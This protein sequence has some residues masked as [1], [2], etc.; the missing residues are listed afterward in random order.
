MD[1]PEMTSLA[2]G[3]PHPSLFP[4]LRAD[5]E[6][7]APTTDLAPAAPGQ[8]TA[9]ETISIQRNGSF[10][11]NTLSRAM[12][13]SESRFTRVYACSLRV[14]T[15]NY[16][17]NSLLSAPLY[18]AGGTGDAHMTKICYDFVKNV[19]K[20]ARSDFQVLLSTGSTDA[21]AKTVQ[22]LCN[23]GEHILVEQFVYP[24]A[25]SFYIPMGCKGVPIDMDGDGMIPSALEDILENWDTSHPGV[26]R[27]H[28]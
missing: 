23:P 7:L 5:I 16:D 11:Q 6:I 27:P 13:Y 10:A 19:Y 14:A 9:G 1:D 4:F 21:W 22:L 12:Q 17:D 15:D 25:Q 8:P 3:L 20:P 26:K 18:T 28:V 2:G 24:S